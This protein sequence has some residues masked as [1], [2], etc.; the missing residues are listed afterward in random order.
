MIED[1]GDAADRVHHT[2]AYMSYAANQPKPVATIIC[3][4]PF[5]VVE[6]RLTTLQALGALRLARA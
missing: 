5:E 2:A 4:A 1:R 6:I 3:V